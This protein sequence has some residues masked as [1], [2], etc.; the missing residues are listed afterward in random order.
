M[1]LIICFSYIGYQDYHFRPIDL[2]KDL[3]TVLNF[4][5]LK[6][7]TLT[8]FSNNTYVITD[9]PVDSFILASLE[10]KYAQ[11]VCLIED[12][13]KIKANQENSVEL[14]KLFCHWWQATDFDG[15]EGIR[16]I[17]SQKSPE[18]LFFYYGGHGIKWNGRKTIMFPTGQGL[19][20]YN[21]KDL[22]NLFKALPKKSETIVVFDACHA[23]AMIKL[24]IK[25]GFNIFG[26]TK[27]EEITKLEYPPMIFIGS[28]KIDQTCGFFDKGGSLFTKYFIR[29]VL[30]STELDNLWMSVEDKILNYRRKRGMKDQNIIVKTNLNTKKL[31]NWFFAPR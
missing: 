11:K 6:E 19:K 17:F 20:I 7:K 3:A 26:N 8:N 1:N 23:E 14:A 31:P 13:T 21:H 18:T 25:L 2:R 22:N 28:T 4:C 10:N 30:K 9:L 24:P 15:L 27:K 29:S 16:K 5:F 12:N